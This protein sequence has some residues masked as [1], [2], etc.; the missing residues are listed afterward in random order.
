MA[1][2]EPLP[3]QEPVSTRD[4]DSNEARLQ[5][6]RDRAR[7]AYEAW[8]HNFDEAERD[9]SFLAGD[10]WPESVRHEREQEQRPCLTINKLPQYVDQ[11]VGDQRMARPAIHVHPV[12]GNMGGNEQTVTNTA[13]T[14]DY[15]LQEVYESIIRNIEYLSTAE[16]HYDK[17]FQ[18]MVEGGFGWLRVLPQYSR[19][20]VFE[21]DLFI[22]SIHNRFAVLMDYESTEPDYSDA[23]WGFISHMMRRQEFKKRYPNAQMGDLTDARMDAYQWWLTEDHVRVAEYMYREPVKRTLYLLND[24][25]TVWHEDFEQIRDELRQQGIKVTREREVTRFK[26]MWSKITAFDILEGPVELP[27]STIP[28]APVLGK[29]VTLGERTYYRGIIRHAHDAQ[30]MHNFWLTAATEK[31]AL[32]PKA[33]YVAPA[34]SIEGFEDEWQQANRKNL[35]VLR[36]RALPDVPAPYREQAA[37]MPAAEMQLALSA[38]DELKATVGLYDASV[39]AQSNETSGV[40]IRSRQSQGDRGMYEY[41]DN[42]A[43]GIQRVGKILIEMIPRIYDS[44][45]IVRLRTQDGKEDWVNINQIVV[46]DETDEEILINDVN[47]GKYDVTVQTGPGH[48]TQR[49][50]AVASLMEFIKAAP[51]SGQFI[52]DVVAR[53]MDWPGAKELAARLKHAVPPQVLS[54]EEKE[55][56][57][58]QDQGPTPEQQAEQAKSKADIAEAKAKERDAQAKERTAE[59]TEA[60]AQADIREAQLKMQEMEQN[61]VDASGGVDEEQIKQMVAEAIV[62]LRQEAEGDAQPDAQMQ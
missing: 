4:S 45:R 7:L 36:Y 52:L 41:T 6:A 13:G 48:Q 22:K 61:G 20:D 24:G 11:V 29:Q 28:I 43:R 8:K 31:V 14:K 50:E 49:Q 15:S 58:I 46:D 51:Q 10:Q 54:D 59:A 55:E 12:E 5:E 1:H 56:A 25:R 23:N 33:P 9:V 3:G 37:Q 2:S 57:G 32:A 34:E 39:G 19:D 35:S 18:H 47:A 16:H 26:V 30:K 44:E 21:Q 42:L 53:N 17:A 62:A 38:S 60:K 27:C 40:A